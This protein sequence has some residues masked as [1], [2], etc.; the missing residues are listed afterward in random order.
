MIL[1]GIRLRRK[2]IFIIIILIAL[3]GCAALYLMA[4]SVLKTFNDPRLIASF[5]QQKLGAPVEIKKVTT[6][7]TG[8]LVLKGVRVNQPAELN[9]E[10]E[11]LVIPEVVIRFQPWKVLA[12]PSLES[13]DRI[14]LIEPTLTLTPRLIDW[15]A[16]RYGKEGALEAMPPLS[17]R[18]GSLDMTV[19]AEAYPLFFREMRGKASV[20]KGGL[21][22]RFRGK[23]EDLVE[24]WEVSGIAGP[25]AHREVQVAIHAMGLEK[26]GERIGR[27]DL[28]LEGKA[29][30]TASMSGTGQPLWKG[31]ISIDRAKLGKV[32]VAGIT[33]QFVQSA[34]KTEIPQCTVKLFGGGF[35]GSG[36]LRQVKSASSLRIKGD[37]LDISLEEVRRIWDRIP[38]R[39]NVSGS[40]SVELTPAK[41]TS[42]G[43]FL[44]KEGTLF[45]STSF[46]RLEGGYCLTP[47]GVILK[48][49]T[50]KTEVG[51]LTLAGTLKK[52]RFRLT[53][54]CREL[55]LKK[56]LEELKS[57]KVAPG[58][59]VK[60]VL[61]GTIDNT[62][63]EGSAEVPSLTVGE[64]MIGKVALQGSLI[65]KGTTVRFSDLALALGKEHLAL[66]GT[67]TRD[68][69]KRLHLSL[70]AISPSLVEA[71]SPVPFS[72]YVKL[73]ADTMNLALEGDKTSMKGTLEAG[74]GAL[75][76]MAF[77]NIS[78][79]FEG[80]GE[81]P[82]AL[83]GT[84]ACQEPLQLEG[85]LD[86][87][88]ADL[89]FATKKC[90]YQDMELRAA[91]LV[92]HQAKG[93]FRGELEAEEIKTGKELFRD[94]KITFSQE[95]AG[96]TTL[97]GS[98]AWHGQVM[99]LSGLLSRA[100]QEVRFS[101]DSFPLGAFSTGHEKAPLEGRAKVEIICRKDKESLRTLVKL[102]SDSLVAGGRKLPPLSSLFTVKDEVLEFSLLRLMGRKS[103]LD[104]TGTLSL[105]NNRAALKAALKDYDLAELSDMLG[106]SSASPPQSP[107]AANAPAAIAGKITGTLSMSGPLEKPE[108]AFEGTATGLGFQDLALGGGKVRFTLGGPTLSGEFTPQAPSVCLA[109][110]MGK[111]KGELSR[112]LG[113]GWKEMRLSFSR[114][115]KEALTVRGEAL[116]EVLGKT[117]FSGVVKDKGWDFTIEP[118]KF[119][120]ESLQ[121]AKPEISLSH[122]GEKLAGTIS[123]PSGRLQEMAVAS[124][125]F[126]FRESQGGGLAFSGSCR[127]EGSE[128]SVE[129]ESAGGALSAVVKFPEMDLKSS[130]FFPLKDDR[131][132]GKAAVE[133]RINEGK[134]KSRKVVVSSESLKWDGKKLPRLTLEGE[135]KKGLFFISALRVHFEDGPLFLAGN[136]SPEKQ[137]LMLNGKIEGNSIPMLV[138]RLGGT[139]PDIQGNLQGALSLSGPLK[140]P[141]F[142]YDGRVLNLVYQGKELGDG[143]LRLSGNSDGMKG[144]LDLDKK[145]KLQVGIS[146]ANVEV[147][148]YFTLE[149]TP[150]NPVVKPHATDTKLHVSP[151]VIWNL[152]RAGTY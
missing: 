27:K 39:G 24:S 8:K 20:K 65:I 52:D 121:F 130:G 137:S 144:R 11:F 124:P 93:S 126:T 66:S 77:K 2:R 21:E 95:V 122:D 152:F 5:L 25:G 23:A 117:L 50:M 135:E 22:F 145:P 64:K 54:G 4:S 57:L 133:V 37:F 6:S 147:S 83:K 109:S 149:G 55:N 48:N 146:Q 59:T 44:M 41:V 108:M 36:E 38:L 87:D 74:K 97:G 42:E 115:D 132:S 9:E 105:K 119:S 1:E 82:L 43:T 91:R 14:D 60:G 70:P 123:A 136:V 101:H 138:D 110:L 106:P 67:L 151:S 62:V 33:S 85:T 13:A 10:G 56:P 47:Q 88:K 16:A 31:S 34:E 89:S 125:R 98:M 51:N 18:S 30:I 26:I 7:Y 96:H 141:D 46:E 72:G 134:E 40:L 3:A 142:S 140:K 116:H 58:G 131:L 90:S 139:M 29:E 28:P 102:A 17:V 112:L 71:F 73:D 45:S 148:Y 99:E 84:V 114:R 143:T 128:A 81:K 104:F 100:S 150:K 68:E 107:P 19:G 86:K 92:V 76:G 111:G 118:E 63:F 75:A 32:E 61:E 53:V 80:G 103:P 113:E 120:L 129:G 94:P 69:K 49:T 15:F 78:L 35:K 79:S 127:L 12:N